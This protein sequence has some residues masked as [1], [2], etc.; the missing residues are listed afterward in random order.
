MCT[1]FTIEF[2]G[3]YIYVR[4]ASDFEFTPEYT[5]S[6]WS[7]LGDEC[8]TYNCRHVLREGRFSLRKMN[9]LEA[10][11]SAIQAANVISG[12]RVACCFKDHTEDEMTKFFK[13]AASNRG[14]EIEFFS[15]CQAA[16]F[17]LGVENYQSN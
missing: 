7:A 1:N 11:N 6:F 15:D 10:Y 16:L 2:R 5:A 14:V 17:W 9:L 3:D 13:M 8:Q 12:L 4:H